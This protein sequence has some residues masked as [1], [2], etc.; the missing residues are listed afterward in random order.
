MT[1]TQKS[2]IF[3]S[4][5]ALMYAVL[6]NY[7]ALPGYLRFLERG[8]TSAAGNSLDLDVILGAARTILWMYSFNLGAMALYWYTLHRNNR[9]Y[10][11]S[12]VIVCVAWLAFWS[13]PSLPRM[14]AA[15]YLLTGSVILVAIVMVHV[16]QAS[17]SKPL[18]SFL[19]STAV[20]FFAMATWDVCGLGSTGRILH[21]DEVILQR[22]QTLLSA[23]TTKLMLA[24]C[25]AWGC[26]A[27]SRSNENSGVS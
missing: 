26:L 18:A 6:G 20:L 5:A 15:F 27:A 1:R 23:Q 17:I 12:G 3:F 19:F 24:M 10:L 13:I 7:L 16:R 25:I 4:L 11:R 9:R 14:P 21:P 2:L 22:S 8:G